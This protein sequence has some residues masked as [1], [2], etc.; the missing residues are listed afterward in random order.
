[1]SVKEAEKLKETEHL[2]VERK[3]GCVLDRMCEILEVALNRPE[4]EDISDENFRL[5]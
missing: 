5:R 4:P 2:E 3:P 1:M